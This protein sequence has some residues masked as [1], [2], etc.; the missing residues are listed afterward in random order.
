M[1]DSHEPGK[2]EQEP[3]GSSQPSPE[4][5]DRDEAKAMWRT[6]GRFGHIGLQFGIATGIGF[7]FGRWLDGKFGT[8]PFLAAFF[9]LCGTASAAIDL[10]RL[11]RRLQRENEV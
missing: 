8:A 6:V 5:N 1:S 7:L 11:V 3:Q 2:V 9:A 10:Y 4:Q